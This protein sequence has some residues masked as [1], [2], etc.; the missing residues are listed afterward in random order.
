VADLLSVVR[1]ALRGGGTVGDGNGTQND[2]YR[3]LGVGHDAS[4]PEIRR[5]YRR[6]ARQHH[7]DRNPEP[8][9]PERFRSLAEAYGVLNDPARR[10]HYDQAT[11]P[12]SR[13]LAPRSRSSAVHRGVLELSAPEARHVAT[14]PL[15]LTTSDGTMIMLPAGLSDGD[16]IIL[17]DRGIRVVLTVRVNFAR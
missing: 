2:Y 5:A 6:L 10:A 3:V 8:D 13:P 15:T 11:R 4:T 12:V 1:A 14:K 17:A 7:P 9:S 16:Q